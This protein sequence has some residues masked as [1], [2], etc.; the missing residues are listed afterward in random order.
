M[1]QQGVHSI[2][3]K[4]TCV[5]AFTFSPWI[6]LKSNELLLFHCLAP[7][8]YSDLKITLGKVNFGGEVYKK[9]TPLA[10]LICIFL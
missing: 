9:G 8:K 1:G 7:Q 3:F 10:F 4:A 5:T 2:L 6:S